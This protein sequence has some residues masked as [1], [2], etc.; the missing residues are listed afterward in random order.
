MADN[1]HPMIP[2]THFGF[3][4]FRW[5]SGFLSTSCSQ[6][7]FCGIGIFSLHGRKGDYIGRSLQSNTNNI[8]RRVWQHIKV[9]NSALLIIYQL[10][11]NFKKKILAFRPIANPNSLFLTI[12]YNHVYC[13]LYHSTLFLLTLPGPVI[14][15]L[16]HLCLWVLARVVAEPDPLTPPGAVQVVEGDQGQQVFQLLQFTCVEAV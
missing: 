8:S 14:Y 1:P 7:Y 9:Y 16:V 3:L 5:G 13:K 12:H 6:V 2:L 15:N 10:I 11:P 4:T